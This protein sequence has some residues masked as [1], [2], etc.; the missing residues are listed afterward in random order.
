MGGSNPISDLID[1]VFDFVGDVFSNFISWIDP[2]PDIPEFDETDVAQGVKLNKVSNNEPIPIVYGERRVGGTFCFVE[3]SGSTNENLFVVMTLCEGEINGVKELVVDDKV[4][5]LASA[6]TL[7]AHGT[8]YTSND[9]RFSNTIQVQAFNGTDDQVASSLITTQSNW[10]SAHRLRGVS[11]LALKFSWNQDYYSGL[12][13]VQATIQGKKI[14]DPRNST[15]A[16]STNPALC[17]LDYLRNSRYGK[18]L[19]DTQFETDFAS[20]K[21]SAN[22]CETQVTP[23]SGAPSTINVFDT[24]AVLPSDQKI[25]DN[26]RELLRGCRGILPYTQGKYKLIIETYGT[27]SLTLTE[28]D[29]LDGIKLRSENLNQKFNRVVVNYINPSN[30]F[31][32][33]QAQ[34]PPVDD[35]SLPT[36]DQ[37]Q[38][39]LT[40]DGKLLQGLFTFNTITSSY[41]AE[42]LAEI[43]LRRSRNALKLSIRCTAEASNL[44]IGDIVNITHSSV[45]FSAKPFR[46]LAIG[47]LADFS[48]QLNLIE[49]Q[50]NHYVWTPKA[51]DPEIVDT[52]LPD[53]YSVLAPTNLRTSDELRVGSGGSVITILNV[54]ADPSLDFFVD[55]YECQYKLTTSSTYITAGIGANPK[56]EIPGL[57][58]GSTYDV[59]IKAINSNRVSSAFLTGQHT[60]TGQLDIPDDVENFSINIVG[61]TAF[62]NWQAVSNL[63]LSYYQIKFNS[64]LTGATWSGSTI[65]VNQVSKP[66]TSVS[67]PAQSGTYLIKAFDLTGNSSVNATSISTSVAS[68]DTTLNNIVSNQQDPAFDGAKSDVIKTLNETLDKNTLVLGGVSLFDSNTGDFDSILDARF[69]SGGQNNN[70]KSTGTYDFDQVIDTTGILTSRITAEIEQTS[71]DRDEIFDFTLGNVDSKVGLF[72]GNAPD[73]VSTQLQIAQ[74]N[75]NVSFTSFQNFLVGDFTARYFKFRLVLNSLNNSATPI[76]FGLKVNIDVPD[77]TLFEN[78]IS[79]GS[80]VQTITYS[81]NFVSLPSLGVSVENQDPGDTF[82]ITNKTTSGFD[83]QLL[84]SSGVGKSGTIDYIAHGF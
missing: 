20:F 2:T 31:E 16:Y 52:N 66:A 81:Q 72:D 30:E 82:S 53:P 17:I 6:P 76:V 61:S 47:L 57:L 34:F 13:R 48:I 41:Q 24:N 50:D 22:E 84:N 21:T 58:D 33:D 56:F 18:G 51:S 9:S 23:Y 11:Y 70:T 44:E 29:I 79:I 71:L 8:T 77:K 59:Q 7:L 73:N 1:D 35:S 49:Y 60:I 36:A 14:F 26:V 32:S 63:D 5:T 40:A 46:V 28:D 83:I 3:T 80:S 65:L 12:P 75:D 25:L 54:E 15:T 67:V 19:A 42:E 62:L 74:S 69:D 64:S 55:V 4:V 45:G 68:V 39:M 27:A 78:N 10:T 43:I 37:H 38:T